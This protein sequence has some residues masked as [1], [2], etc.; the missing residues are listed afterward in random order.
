MVDRIRTR[1]IPQKEDDI[2]RT[3]A[4]SPSNGQSSSALNACLFLLY[5]SLEPSF[6]IQ[7]IQL[8]KDTNTTLWTINAVKSQISPPTE[9]SQHNPRVPRHSLHARLQVIQPFN[10][11]K[12]L[13]LFTP[14]LGGA[15]RLRVRGCKSTIKSERSTYLWRA[16]T[17][18]Y[19]PRNVK[20]HRRRSLSELEWQQRF[21]WPC[22]KLSK[23]MRLLRWPWL[24]L[25]RPS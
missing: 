11:F 5:T 20:E 18:L 23:E 25:P 13:N 15:S 16:I 19:R 21:I 6:L 3:T 2:A 14:T 4:S 12:W 8:I 9:S 10:P 17:F 24:F 7:L 1:I 22:S